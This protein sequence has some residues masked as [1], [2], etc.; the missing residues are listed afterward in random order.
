MACGHPRLDPSKRRRSGGYRGTVQ[1]RT[2]TY[3]HLGLEADNEYHRSVSQQADELD[4]PKLTPWPPPQGGYRRILRP[5]RRAESRRPLKAGEI[6]VL[7]TLFLL[8]TA[9]AVAM[10]VAGP[11]APSLW[12]AAAIGVAV[13][14]PGILLSWLLTP[15]GR[16]WLLQIAGLRTAANRDC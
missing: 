8:A 1:V 13:T 14:G 3:I 7:R 10:L 5:D 11:T 15:F 9:V 6:A 4:R 2:A 16:H 12:H